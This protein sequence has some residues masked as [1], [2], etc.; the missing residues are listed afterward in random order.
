MKMLMGQQQAKSLIKTRKILSMITAITQ[1]I[2]TTPK[3]IIFAQ[4]LRL[5]ANLVVKAFPKK[6]IKKRKI[7]QKNE[8]GLMSLQGPVAEMMNSR[9]QAKPDI[10]KTMIE[11]LIDLPQCW[12]KDLE[13]L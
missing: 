12:L 7:L 3:M 6:L 5:E 2:K 8:F 13:L 9:I 1:L 4:A 11:V 10:K